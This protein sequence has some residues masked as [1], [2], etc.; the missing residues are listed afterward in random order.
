MSDR[1]KNATYP[2]RGIIIGQSPNS[3]SMIQLYWIMGRSEGSRNR[4]LVVENGAARTEAFDPSRLENPS[5]LVYSPLGVVGSSHVVTNGD[6]TD[7]IV[8]ALRS[9]C[10]FESALMSRTYEEDPPINTPRISGIVE[11]ETGTYKLAV[12]KALESGVAS[13]QFFTYEAGIPGTGHCITTY[14]D[15]GDP[16][17]AFQGEPFTVALSDSLDSNAEELW[18]LLDEDNKVALLAKS[19]DIESGG[20][21]LKVINKYG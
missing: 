6:Q 5:L 10:T 20:S 14:V 12:L 13:R 9:G 2:G 17:P 18:G 1:L 4:V 8:E 19:I 15:D 3:K 7:T 11:Q 16:P 21:H